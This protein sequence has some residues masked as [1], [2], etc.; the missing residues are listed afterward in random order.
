MFIPEGPTGCCLMNSDG[1]IVTMDKEVA[2]ILKKTGDH[3]DIMKD[4]KKKLCE[5]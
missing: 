1:L 4:L 3:I 2:Y 5:D